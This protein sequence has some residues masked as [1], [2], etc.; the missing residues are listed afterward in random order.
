M[1][2]S[3]FPVIVSPMKKT[4]SSFLSRWWLLI[5]IVVIVT[6]IVL[7]FLTGFRIGP[8]ASIVRV[9][10][11]VLE[12]V[13]AGASV[14]VDEA[15]SRTSGGGLVRI[16][17]LP[18]NHVVIVSV[19][20]AQPWNELITIASDAE[21]IARPIIIPVK[22][23]V[24]PIPAE[25]TA[26][27]AADVSKTKLPTLQAPLTLAGGCALVYVSGKN[28]VAEA[29]TTPTCTPPPYLCVEEGCGPTAVMTP[30]ENI[31][32]VLPYPG[33]DDVLVISVGQTLFVLEL[34]P[35]AP[36][37]FAPLLR[38][39][40]PRAASWSDGSVVVYSDQKLYVVNL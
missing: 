4:E 14:Y 25:D 12:D 3:L 26:K 39:T 22:V 21:T 15:Y 34:D 24:A 30:V 10:T 36:Q 9:G 40:N 31:N 32:S 33:R 28:I 29:S 8:G 23:T 16:G 13:P 2:G 5:A 6:A 27:A 17:M 19:E 38:G 37:F 1:R 11:L 35:R 7:F 18:G 20:G